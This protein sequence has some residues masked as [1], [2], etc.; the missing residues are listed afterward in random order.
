MST[1]FVTCNATAHLSNMSGRA[2]LTARGHYFVVDALPSLSGPNEEINPVEALMSA[3]A[4]S[5]AFICEA[6]AND[7][8]IPL[9]SLNVT[10]AGDFDPRGICGEDVAAN[11]QVFRVKLTVGGATQAQAE[12]LVEA[13][14]KRCPIYSTLVRAASI[15]IQVELLPEQKEKP[16][17]RKIRCRDVGFDCPHEVEAENDEQV[18]AQV[19]KH[20]A[21]VHGVVVTEDMATQVRTLI[22]DSD[23][24]QA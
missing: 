18:L 13:F 12:H 11:I 1:P 9:S 19:A 16:K 7:E 6:V 22:R 8:H 14:T 24:A 15:D 3:L 4:S 17:M 2:I 20:A 23:D 21:E 10:V 5:C